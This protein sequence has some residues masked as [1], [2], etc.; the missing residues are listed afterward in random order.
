MARAMRASGE[1]KPKA[2]RVSRRSRVFMDSTRAL[3]RS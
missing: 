1:R 3:E 2:M